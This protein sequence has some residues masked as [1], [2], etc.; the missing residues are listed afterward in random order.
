MISEEN[1]RLAVANVIRSFQVELLP[2]VRL[3]FR[4]QEVLTMMQKGDR[5][6][7]E[8]A[9]IRGLDRWVPDRTRLMSVLNVLGVAA[10]LEYKI[11]ESNLLEEK[12]EHE[13]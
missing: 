8:R 11:L 13:Y 10:S 3:V 2:L 6:G 5:E 7:L 9:L 4:E 1:F 12:N